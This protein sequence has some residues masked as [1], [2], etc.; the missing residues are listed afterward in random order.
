MDLDG[1]GGGDEK[2]SD[3]GGRALRDRVS[4]RMKG[5]EDG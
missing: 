2:R 4:E 3:S 1:S 5:A